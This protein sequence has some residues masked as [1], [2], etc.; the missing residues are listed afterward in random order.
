MKLSYLKSEIAKLDLNSKIKGFSGFEESLEFEHFKTFFAMLDEPKY[1][2]MQF[3]NS[4]AFNT[5]EDTW[6][7]CIP[8]DGQMCVVDCGT[9]D[10]ICEQYLRLME[11]LAHGFG[12]INFEKK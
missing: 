4:E 7:L 2:I 5:S 9:E 10:E 11:I 1:S 8:R 3:R 6:V 12:T